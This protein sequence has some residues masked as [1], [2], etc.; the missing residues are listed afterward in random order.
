[1][2]QVLGRCYGDFYC[3][4]NYSWERLSWL[5]RYSFSLFSFWYTWVTFLLTNL[6]KG[7]FYMADRP[8][9]RIEILGQATLGTGHFGPTCYH[10]L[11]PA[12][13]ARK[14]SLLFPA[15]LNCSKTFVYQG[16]VRRTGPWY[17]GPASI[18]VVALVLSLMACHKWNFLGLCNLNQV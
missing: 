13:F 11:W 7:F 18:A 10:H 16:P 4:C 17:T 12:R 15:Y 14:I 8:P 6:S 2:C 5:F 3:T 1:M 9:A